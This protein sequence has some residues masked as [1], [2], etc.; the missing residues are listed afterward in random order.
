MDEKR[1]ITTAQD[2]DRNSFDQLI[3]LNLKKSQNTLYRSYPNLLPDEFNEILQL[4]LIRAW[5]K[6]INFNS[7]SCFFTWFFV[8]LKNETSTFLTNKT[9]AQKL[10]TSLDN[11]TVERDLDFEN[12]NNFPFNE[13]QDE[14]IWVNPQILLEAKEKSQI[15]REMLQITSAKLSKKHAEVLKL[16]LDEDLSYKEMADVLHLSTGTVMS[17]LHYAKQRFRAFILEYSK[18]NKLDLDNSLLAR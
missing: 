5:T 14:S 6:I 8:I 16:Y 12:S 9:K 2:G 11:F 4:T 3:K 15:L 13:I 7:N 17:R 18:N 1:L 10:E